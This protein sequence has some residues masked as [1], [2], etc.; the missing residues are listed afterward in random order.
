MKRALPLVLL[1]LSQS[2]LADSSFVQGVKN[3][4]QKY[5]NVDASDWYNKGDTAFAEYTGDN[6]GVYQHLKASVRNYSINIKMEYAPGGDMSNTNHFMKM[7]TAVCRQV[8]RQV[9]LTPEE[10]EKLRAWDDSVKD[11]F[12]FMKSETLSDAGRDYKQTSI[13]GWSVKIKRAEMMT[14]CSAQKQ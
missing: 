12:D 7:T 6:F 4:F 2:T 5:T 3:V 9:I 10:L 14:T 1:L 11:P 8:F 13:N